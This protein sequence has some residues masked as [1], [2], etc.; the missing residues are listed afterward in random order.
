MGPHS[1]GLSWLLGLFFLLFVNVQSQTIWTLLLAD[2][3][4]T[5]LVSMARNFPGQIVQILNGTAGVNVTLFAPTNEAFAKFEAQI[6]TSVGV[7]I[8]I[9]NAT[10]P[11]FSDTLLYH[12][13]ANVLLSSNLTN[14]RL[15]MANMNQALLTMRSPSLFI[16]QGQIIK[17]DQLATNGVLHTVNQVIVPN[18]TLAHL[19]AREDEYSLLISLGQHSEPVIAAW[20]SFAA[21]FNTYLAP[22]NA[23]VKRALEEI[24]AAGES[25]EALITN[26]QA[27]EKILFYHALNKPVF[28]KSDKDFPLNSSQFSDG[29]VHRSLLGEPVLSVVEKNM[30]FVNNAQLQ[31]GQVDIELTNSILQGVNEMLIPDT[32][33]VSIIEEEEFSALESA[34]ILSNST[35]FYVSLF[36]S[37]ELGPKT[38]FAPTNDALASAPFLPAIDPLLDYHFAFGVFNNVGFIDGQ[39]LEMANGGKTLVLKDATTK[40]VQV[41]SAKLNEPGQIRSNGY[42]YTIDEILLPNNS[43][44]VL[45]RNE[46][47]STLVGLVARFP[48]FVNFLSASTASPGTLFAPDNAAFND[49]LE[50]LSYNSV[51]ADASLCWILSYHFVTN[52]SWFVTP[53]TRFQDRMFFFDNQ[54]LVASRD[55]PDLP[56]PGMPGPGAGAINMTVNSTGTFPNDAKITKAN[57]LESNGTWVFHVVNQVLLPTQLRQPTYPTY[58]P[59]TTHPAYPTY[60]PTYPTDYPGTGNGV[61]YTFFAATDSK[62]KCSGSPGQ[63]LENLGFILTAN[64][65]MAGLGECRQLAQHN[66]DNMFEY[67]RTMSCNSEVIVTEIFSNVPAGF[68]CSGRPTRVDHDL[69]GRCK[70]LES[71]GSGAYKARCLSAEG[72]ASYQSQTS[73]GAQSNNYAGQSNFAGQS[74]SQAS[75]NGQVQHVYGGQTQQTYTAQTKGDASYG[76]MQQQGSY[77][78]QQGQTQPIYTAQTKGDGGYSKADGGYDESNKGYQSGG[79]YGSQSG[80]SYG[81]QSG[82]TYGSQSGG[83]YDGSQLGG[84]YGSQSGGSYGSPSGGSYGSQ[85]GGSYGSQSGSTYGG[86]YGSQ[87]G[88]S[89][90]SQS[91]GTYGAQSGGSYASQSGGSYGLQSGGSY[92]SHSGGNYGSQSGGS[93]GSQS[94]GNYGSQSGVSYGSQSGGYYGSQSGGTYGLQSGGTYGS[95]SGG[96]Y[97]AHS[98][99]GYGS[100]SGGSYGSQSGGSYGS[101]SGSRYGAQS[102][103]S[104]GSQSSGTYGSGGSYGSQSG[105]SYGSPSGGSYGAQSGGSYGSQSGGTYGSQSGGS[106]SSQSGGSY[107][108]QSG[109]SYGSQSGGSYGGQSSSYVGQ[110]KSYGGQSS[111]YEGQSKFGGQPSYGGQA[112]GYGRRL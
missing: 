23:A 42:L 19:L 67:A 43:L 59:Y 44:S 49:L 10:D 72:G 18:S 93:Y 69:T 87:S 109:G 111:N 27:I 103:G 84:T 81:S 90:G 77:G 105:G 61:I 24:D 112:V 33:L 31:P 46:Q 94:G 36:S 32:I 108:S 37:L 54:S 6:K 9:L 5:K 11:F 26:T 28:V 102:G 83:S 40:V 73:Y 34:I 74:S 92:G 89:Y 53:D 96:S 107:G 22:N 35:L 51:L 7:D 58:A 14:Q 91:G 65:V 63:A 21:G 106:Y 50:L 4:Y 68:D 82:G 97:G 56:P 13:T 41:N 15:M 71:F 95:Q 110:T 20:S 100:Q 104:Y 64:P 2:P 47:L 45:L 76:H 12:V 1:A 16:N 70:S 85:S 75:Y 88:G 99:G 60:N 86:S 52:G 57:V 3:Q 17:A 80:G 101:Q 98:G 29:Q 8:N 30:I 79:S 25:V 62:K 38:L 66:Y 48:V 55:C 39:H 78:G